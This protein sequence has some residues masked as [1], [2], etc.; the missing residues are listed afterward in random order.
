MLIAG[1]ATLVMVS[2]AKAD[3]PISIFADMPTHVERAEDIMIARCVA[4]AK[5]VK[6][7]ISAVLLS[8]DFEVL[9]VLK[10]SRA[11]GKLRVAHWSFVESSRI[12]LLF[13]C[14]GS[15]N[16]TTFLATFPEL[17]IIEIPN[18]FKLSNLDGRTTIELVNAIFKARKRQVEQELTVLQIERSLLRKAIGAPNKP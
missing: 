15:A 14:G 3:L 16:G 1:L 8:S 13:N 5:G 2:T 17:G 12:Y 9:R 6:Y 4:A 10:G 7:P 18:W 11:K